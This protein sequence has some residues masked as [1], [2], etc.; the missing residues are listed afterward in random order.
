ML[1]HLNIRT[2]V[3]CA[4]FVCFT[5]LPN[6]QERNW[7]SYKFNLKDL[8]DKRKSSVVLRHAKDFLN[9][10]DYAAILVDS[11]LRRIPYSSWLGVASTFKHSS[12]WKMCK[13]HFMPLGVLRIRYSFA[14]F[15][16]ERQSPPPP[17]STLDDLDDTNV[18]ECTIFLRKKITRNAKNFKW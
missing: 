14:M 15:N 3:I 13:W 8:D 6:K 11:L 18:T 7:S 2:S 1:D 17:L 9:K 5:Q 16:H 10:T 4:P 12:I